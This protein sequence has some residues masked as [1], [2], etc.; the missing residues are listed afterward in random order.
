MIDNVRFQKS[1][2]YIEVKDGKYFVNIEMSTS[3]GKDSILIDLPALE[4]H[5][6][7][8]RED[9]IDQEIHDAILSF[10]H[11]WIKVKGE[12]LFVE[13]MNSLGFEKKSIEA[14]IEPTVFAKRA[15]T[16][17]SYS[18]DKTLKK[19]SEEFELA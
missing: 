5:S 1:E 3:K 14:A 2:E 19:Y 4:I 11:H 6:Y 12:Q 8:S 16:L 13:H 7:A 18:T 15:S 10:I 17:S 9:K